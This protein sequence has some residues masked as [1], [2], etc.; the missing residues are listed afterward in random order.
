MRRRFI[1]LC[2][3]ALFVSAAACAPGSSERPVADST[4]APTPT[5]KETLRAV[6]RPPADPRE[7]TSVAAPK[8]PAGW[9]EVYDEAK[10]GIVR[11]DTAN[12][13]GE[14]TGSGFLI[15]ENLVAT[16]A[17]VVEG[18]GRLRLTDP[19][20]GIA[21]GGDVIGL[22]RDHDLALIRTYASLPDGHVFDLDSEYPKIGTD[23]LAIGFP[24][25][26]SIALNKGTITR[27]H[28][29]RTVGE[30]ESA[31]HLSNQVLSDAAL[32]PGNSGGPWLDPAGRVIALDESGPPYDDQSEDR[33]QGLN[34]GV[35]AESAAQLFAGWKQ[36]PMD[37]PAGD[38][39][40]RE[41]PVK[42]QD[43]L[44]WH[45]FMINQSDYASAYAQLGPTAR[46][47]QTLERFIDGHVSSQ[48]QAQ[49]GDGL[50]DVDAS[51]VDATGADYLDVR[52]SSEQDADKS[53]NGQ[54]C[55]SWALRY[56]FEIQN[57]LWLIRSAR[58]VPGTDAGASC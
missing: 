37:I 44:K 50:F 38:C 51:G 34:G 9:D 56:T 49:D 57:G 46:R 15:A 19:E 30:G 5:V 47:G 45:F 43:T 2:S 35:P 52:Y 12:C 31:F 41:V 6:P 24:L 40:G 55:T 11:I 17:H 33:A 28:E 3:A 18:A 23:M 1:G 14:R 21:T 22:D 13:E 32:N 42:M 7:S 26:Q 58:P 4:S 8:A 16:V 36:E 53:S 29:R 27:L 54:T 25:G 48:I 39:A 20:L 10:T